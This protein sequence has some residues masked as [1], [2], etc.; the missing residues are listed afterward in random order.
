MY[1]SGGF[2][3]KLLLTVLFIF[4]K[5]IEADYTQVGFYDFLSKRV[6]YGNLIKSEQIKGYLRI[7]DKEDDGVIFEI[8]HNTDGHNTFKYLAAVNDQEYILV[9]D[10]Y[11]PF[12]LD[13][14][15]KYKQTSLLK[16]DLSG[17]LLATYYLE[18]K[19]VSYGNH[20]NKLFLVFLDYELIFDENLEIVPKIETTI[21]AVGDF[22]YQYQGFLKINGLSASEI[23]LD[24]PGIY[25][26]DITQRDYHYS[27]T[28]TLHPDYKING[29]SFSEGFLGTV[30]FYSFG[31]L[32]LNNSVY[33]IGSDIDTVGLNKIMILGQNNYRL[34]LEIIILPDVVFND[35]ISQNQL[36]A[37]ANFNN[38]I[39]VYS[40][41]ISMFLN[42]EHYASTWIDKPGNY[43][44]ILYGI[45]NYQVEIPFIILPSVS[46]VENNG[47]YKEVNLAI[48]GKALLNGKEITGEYRVV[49]ENEYQLQL[50]LDDEVY[51]TINFTIS[52]SDVVADEANQ[53][54]IPYV[55]YI[56]LILVLVGGGMLIL[57]KK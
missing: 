42:D 16:Y 29:D 44:I 21:E 12:V 27:F 51:Q 50:L 4:M 32:Y 5:V 45:N 23:V 20:G 9:C 33:K 47:L 35:G 53:T 38:P 49:E 34:D 26:I 48:F 19:P 7:I 1:L 28:L 14:E 57:R 40:N 2:F 24:Y 30:K 36:I 17:E 10:E 43:Q 31:E 46:G 39:R 37:N 54:I 3:M 8:V 22:H 11:Y 6:E 13:N 15:E 56:F 18:D 25:R 52:N 55:K 41:A